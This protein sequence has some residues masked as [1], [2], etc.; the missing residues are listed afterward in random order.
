MIFGPGSPSPGV[1]EGDAI[2]GAMQAR[3]AQSH[4]TTRHVLSNIRM[5]ANEDG[6]VACDSL[7]TLFRSESDVLDTIPAIVADIREVFVKDAGGW[8]MQEREI[9]PVFNRQAAGSTGA[10]TQ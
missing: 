1:V 6:S 10:I 3:Q 8:K 4:V 5:N 9:L 2:P 7:L